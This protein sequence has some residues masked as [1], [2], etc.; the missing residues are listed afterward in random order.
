MN[1]YIDRFIH[2]TI[3][4]AFENISSLKIELFSNRITEDIIEDALSI[5]SDREISARSKLGYGRKTKKKPENIEEQQQ[6][7]LFNQMLCHS[8]SIARSDEKSIDSFVNNIAQQVYMNSFNQLK[9]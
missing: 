2:S 1:S 8:S 7:S 9:S 3:K 4:Q 5:I 6:T